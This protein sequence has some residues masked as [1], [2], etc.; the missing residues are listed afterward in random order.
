MQQLES[1]L[2]T[3][4]I[5]KEGLGNELDKVNMCTVSVNVY[6]SA[7]KIWWNRSSIPHTRSPH[8]AI[9]IH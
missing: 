6:I 9:C 5:V 7:M 3:L 8:L 4:D 2:A 1:E